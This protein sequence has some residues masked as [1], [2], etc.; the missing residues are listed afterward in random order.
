MARAWLKTLASSALSDVVEIVGLVDIDLAASESL[1]GEA[2]LDKG[3]AGCDL[4]DILGR[5]KPVVP[6]AR[7]AS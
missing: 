2:K 6:D 5:C 1:C 3:V 4:A 7:Q